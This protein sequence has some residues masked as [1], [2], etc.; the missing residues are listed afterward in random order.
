MTW[1]KGGVD[2]Y[3]KQ[4]D[5][6]TASYMACDKQY[7]ESTVPGWMY[8]SYFTH[9]YNLCDNPSEFDQQFFRNCLAWHS[10]PNRIVLSSGA[11]FEQVDRGVM[12]SGSLFTIDFNS[13]AQVYIKAW[14]CITEYGYWDSHD[15]FCDAVGDDTLDR[16]PPG[17]DEKYIDFINEK[18]FVAHEYHSGHLIELD[19]VGNSFKRVGCQVHIVPAYFEKHLWAL[20]MKDAKSFGE[21][22][23]VLHSHCINYAMSDKFE[24]FHGLLLKYGAV[25][26]RRSA[27]W[28][29]NLH[30]KKE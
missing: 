27:Q 21:F 20:Q 17:F 19:F 18:G 26:L 30:Y 23:Q 8:D 10:K 14:A 3:F 9:V 11:V 7:W 22:E 15:M 4:R 29:Q 28:F 1:L 2:R 13:F 16:N 24:F 5:D 25:E 6:F 12:K